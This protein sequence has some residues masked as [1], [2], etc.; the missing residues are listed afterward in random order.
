MSED[1][2]KWELAFQKDEGTH[3]KMIFG[4]KGVYK[5]IGNGLSKLDLCNIRN[6]KFLNFVIV[7]EKFS[8][9][10]YYIMSTPEN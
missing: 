9:Y 7:G 2:A 8:P 6:K 4:E 1:Q 10:S 5:R 3:L